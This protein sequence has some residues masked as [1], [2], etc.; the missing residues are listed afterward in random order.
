MHD[1]EPLYNLHLL[2]TIQNQGHLL[3]F[4]AASPKSAYL[5]IGKNDDVYFSNPHSLAAN[6]AKERLFGIPRIRR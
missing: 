2:S 4:P 3:T 1:D 6:H 5:A